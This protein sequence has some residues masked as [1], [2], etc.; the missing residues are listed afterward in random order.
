MGVEASGTVV[1]L[2][3]EVIY[4]S[5]IAAVCFTVIQ[6]TRNAYEGCKEQNFISQTSEEQ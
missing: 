6:K 2:G 3:I 4:G 5:A 1:L